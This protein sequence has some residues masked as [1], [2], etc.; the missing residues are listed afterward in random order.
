MIKKLIVEFPVKHS[1]VFCDQWTDFTLFY[2][3]FCD[4]SSNNLRLLSSA[5]Y[6]CWCILYWRKRKIFSRYFLFLTSLVKCV[7]LFSL[8]IVACANIPF[9]SW[10][11]FLYYTIRMSDI[12]SCIF[13]NIFMT[14]GR[15]FLTRES[16]IKE[17]SE[18]KTMAVLRI[19]FK[20]PGSHT[21]LPTVWR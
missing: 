10:D 14:E 3:T 20:F 7:F 6:T 9:I 11:G 13:H 12:Y 2:E 15:A 5:Q 17:K 4:N 19:Q 21:L 16:W 1:K 8:C 18:A